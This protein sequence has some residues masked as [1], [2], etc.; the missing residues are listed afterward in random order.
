MDSSTKAVSPPRTP[1]TVLY[2]STDPIPAV[3]ASSLPN[4]IKDVDFDEFDPRSSKAPTSGIILF[5]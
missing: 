4:K 2:E 3:A 5:M 1:P